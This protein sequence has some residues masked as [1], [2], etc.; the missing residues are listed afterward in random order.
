MVAVRRLV[1]GLLAETVPVCGG[2]L[3]GRTRHRRHDSADPPFTP[4]F[5]R[6]LTLGTRI[7][8]CLCDLETVRVHDGALVYLCRSELHA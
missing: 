1:E 5:H 7:I 2:R 3:F 6:E 8:I 4:D